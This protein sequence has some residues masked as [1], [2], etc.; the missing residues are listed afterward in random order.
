MV[1]PRAFLWFG[2]FKRTASGGCGGGTAEIVRQ[3]VQGGCFATRFLIRTH[4][5]RRII[6]EQNIW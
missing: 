2:Q 4:F 6:R 3:F 5:R 1:P